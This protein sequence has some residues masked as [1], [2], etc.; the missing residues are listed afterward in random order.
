MVKNKK[1]TLKEL[2]IAKKLLLNS[3]ELI[4]SDTLENII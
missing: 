2:I 1:N 3:E 4:K